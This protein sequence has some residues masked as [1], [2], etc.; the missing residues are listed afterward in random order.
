[1]CH[2]QHATALPGN[3]LSSTFLGLTQD[4]LNQKLQVGPSELQVKEPSRWF[5]TMLKWKTGYNNNSL[6][7]H[8]KA[9]YSLFP[10]HFPS[11]IQPL[12]WPTSQPWHWGHC[13]IDESP[14]HTQLF[15]SSFLLCYH[16]YDLVWLH[17][18][19]FANPLLYLSSPPST[20][21]SCGRNYSFLSPKALCL[22]CTI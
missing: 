1:M 3:L 9:L 10:A 7:Y 22:S 8:Y 21:L 19:H 16:P 13:I 18:T 4:W 17:H 15:K 2:P 6:D 5:S 20:L 14:N 12:P 11:C